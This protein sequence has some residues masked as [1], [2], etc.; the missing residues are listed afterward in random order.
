MN[1]IIQIFYD[2]KDAGWDVIVRSR[3]TNSETGFYHF[4]K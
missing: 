3:K 2:L 1:N 4:E